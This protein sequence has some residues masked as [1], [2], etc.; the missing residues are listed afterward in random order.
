MLA[1]ASMRSEPNLRAEHG[2]D[3]ALRKRWIGVDAEGRAM[4]A[5]AVRANN[6][7]GAI[8]AELLCLAPAERLRQAQAWGLA[9]RLCRRLTGPS[10]EALAATELTIEDDRLVLRAHGDMAVLYGDTVARDHRWLAETLGLEAVFK[11]G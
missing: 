2:T 6:G 4:L 9:T 8:P 7:R 10:A 5:M 1:L 3:W 11:L